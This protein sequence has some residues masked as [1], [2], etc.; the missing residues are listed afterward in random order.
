MYVYL[1]GPLGVVLAVVL[2]YGPFRIA[3][4]TYAWLATLVFVLGLIEYFSGFFP[5]LNFLYLLFLFLLF[6]VTM[7]IRLLIARSLFHIGRTRYLKPL[8]IGLLI[9]LAFALFNGVALIVLPIAIAIYRSKKRPRGPRPVGQPSGF[10]GSLESVRKNLSSLGPLALIT[11][12]GTLAIAISSGIA[13]TATAISAAATYSEQVQ[14]IKARMTNSLPP[15]AAND[16]PI[17]ERTNAAIVL[18]NSIGGLGPQYHVSNQGLSLVRYHGQ[19][20]WTA[21][22]DYNNG[23]IWLTKHTTPGYVYT[24][25]SNPSAKPVL[26][27]NAEYTITPQAGFGYNLQRVLYQ[28]FPTLYIGTSDW[29]LNPSGEGYWVTSLYEPAPG[30][31]GLVTKVIVGSALTN[32]TTGHVHFFALGQQPAWVSQVVGP[33]FAQNE[34]MRYGWDRAG[35]IA[36]TFTHQLTTE[37]VHATPYNVLLSN[38]DL[39][40]EI[41]MTSPS[42]ND[43]SLSGLILVNA[44]TNAV[45]YTP[46]TGMQ[47]DL[48]AEQRINGATLNSSLSA[49]RPLLYNISGGYAYVAPVINQSGIVQEIALVD[50]RNTVQPIISPTMQDALASWQNYLAT[51]GVTSAT[52]TV[53]SK[54]LTGIVKRVATVL[55]SSGANGAPVKEYWLFLIGNQAYRASLSI[56]P[57]VVPFVRP[58]DTVTIAFATGQAAPITIRS[59]RDVTLGK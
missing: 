43:N 23:L 22:L 14:L 58:G 41:P 10:W 33:E 15:V 21:P 49:G 4:K 46:F 2:G 47:N 5:T 44:E 32:P 59:I 51:G 19:L 1:L 56:N 45:S 38:G 24:S 57:N 50:P 27:Q 48:A 37:P 36:S 52:K 18:S 7:G 55:S 9:L 13:A 8:A 16:V 30:L 31:A 34:A 42:T 6:S 25:A 35:L 29:E 20:I 3:R 11:A 40:W 12:I 26:V 17:V 28:H 54:V 39:A 53:Q